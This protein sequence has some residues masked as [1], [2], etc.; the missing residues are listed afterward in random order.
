MQTYIHTQG[1]NTQERTS[2][3]GGGGAIQNIHMEADIHIGGAYTWRSINTE[4]H[5]HEG[6]QE[7]IHIHG[8]T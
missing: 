7:E 4:G 6:I 2:Y 8:G 3:G 5:T 1:E